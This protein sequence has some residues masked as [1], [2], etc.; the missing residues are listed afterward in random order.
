MEAFVAAL[1]RTTITPVALVRPLQF[2]RL[3]PL[4]SSAAEVVSHG[5]HL[6]LQ[7][8][9][10][11]YAV[12]G[13][14]GFVLKKSLPWILFFGVLLLL[15][16]S[17]SPYVKIFDSVR[18]LLALE[19]WPVFLFPCFAPG[20]GIEVTTQQAATPPRPMRSTISFLP[21]CAATAIRS[22]QSK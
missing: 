18:G 7:A 2:R 13:R 16:F 14:G 9:R 6:F 5:F 22:G 4:L 12:G 1:D 10:Q 17:N 19:F 3:A 8:H 15:V 11:C 20:G 21:R